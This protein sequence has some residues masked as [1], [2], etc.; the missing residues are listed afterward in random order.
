MD[1]KVWHSGSCH[2]EAVKFRVLAAADL[3][4]YKCNCSVCWMKQVNFLLFC[5]S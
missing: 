4:V 2:C 1:L 3:D 5:V